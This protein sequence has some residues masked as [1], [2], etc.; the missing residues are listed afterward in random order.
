MVKW[1]SH[2]PEGAVVTVTVMW[3][4]LAR[5]EKAKHEDSKRKALNDAEQ[6]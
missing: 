1:R 2:G 4:F 3:H 5:E 6:G